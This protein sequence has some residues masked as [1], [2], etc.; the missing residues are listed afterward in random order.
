MRVDARTAK[1]FSVKRVRLLVSWLVS[2][3]K[4]SSVKLVKLHVRLEVLVRQLASCLV[5]PRV[6]PEGLVSL[7][8]RSVKLLV[9]WLARPLVRLLVKL[10]VR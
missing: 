4:E 9:S 3:V 10:V 7:H 6:K 2:L 1:V 8:V 5:R